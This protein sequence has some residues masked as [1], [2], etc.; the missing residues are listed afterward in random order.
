MAAGD[1]EFRWVEPNG[2]THYLPCIEERKVTFKLNQ[3]T[4]AEL[5]IP[6]D[7]EAG[8][9]IATNAEATGGW[10]YVL[11]YYK[12]A[13]KSV[14]E[15][16]S[17]DVGPRTGEGLAS[18]ALVCTESAFQ[19]LDTQSI[20]WVQPFQFPTATREAGLAVTET[21]FITPP[22]ATNLTG[23]EK[24]T[25]GTTAT[26]APST[27][28][29][30]M[31]KLALLQALAFRGSGFDFWFTPKN[32]AFDPTTAYTSG[33]KTFPR[34]AAVHGVLNIASIRG[35]LRANARMEFG[36][37]TNN[38][39]SSYSWKR[40]GGDHLANT[41]YVPPSGGS[42]DNAAGTVSAAEPVVVGYST[43]IG[44]DR[45]RLITSDFD[46]KALRTALAQAH[47]DYRKR[48]RR[49]L[50]IT[51]QPRFPGSPVPEPLVDYDVGDILPT[52]I[53]DAGVDIVSGNVRVYG[54]NFTIDRDGKETLEIDTVPND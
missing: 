22:G 48:P 11:V 9:Y 41:F 51:P 7:T 13:L 38:F 27:F 36:S 30:G 8:R 6:L 17:T 43:V 42:A 46:D 23:M 12:G 49:I 52:T 50:S 31:T 33:S 2:L 21:P 44:H 37:G 14:L 19:R 15:T 29:S 47:V 3:P 26:I 34:R 39:L 45:A 16:V 5:T 35:A 28:E 54:L 20:D 1:W 53:K 4:T 24:G 10:G 32:G 18:V 25:V 40:L